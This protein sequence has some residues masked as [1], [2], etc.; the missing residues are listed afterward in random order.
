MKLLVVRLPPFSCCFI[1]LSPN[2]PVRTLFSN[3]LSLCSS[4]NARDQVSH[5]YKTTGRKFVTL[6]FVFMVLT[7]N[8]DYFLNQRYPGGRGMWHAWERRGKCSRFWWESPR[9]G[10]HLEDQGIDGKMGSEWI[11]GRLTLGV[12][13]GLDWLRQGPV[14]GCCECGDEPSG[15]CATELV[16]V[17]QLIFAM[18]KCGVIFEV[19]TEFLNIILMSFGFKELN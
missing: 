16:S 6:H 14:A 9:E 17:I 15:S 1:P 11:L 19:R 4:H 8:S 18:V 12:W 3:T 5:P 13:I 7:V 10:D 2:I